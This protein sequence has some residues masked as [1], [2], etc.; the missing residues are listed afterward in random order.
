[1]QLEG[2]DDLGNFDWSGLATNLT[3]VVKQ[4][5][6]VVL[7]AKQQRDLQKLNVARAKAGQ[8]PLDVAQYAEASAPVV[9]VQGGVDRDTRK[10]MLIGGGLALLVVGLI[11]WKALK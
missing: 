2:I 8:A 5:A 4:A 7:A 9:R 3:N 11:A 1:M 6:P 10:T